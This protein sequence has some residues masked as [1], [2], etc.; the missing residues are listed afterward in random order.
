M[1]YKKTDRNMTFAEVDIKG[2]MEHNRS[3]KMMERINEAIDWSKIEP[4]LM[5]H[6]PVGTSSEGLSP[7]DVIEGLPFTKVVLDQLRSGTGKPDQW[8]DFFQEV[9]WPFF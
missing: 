6:Y 5:K 9:S 8:P 7:H 4:I 2:S 3:L 1:G